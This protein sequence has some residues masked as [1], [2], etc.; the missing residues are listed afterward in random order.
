MFAY[1]PAGNNLDDAAPASRIL[2]LVRQLLILL[3]YALAFTGLRYVASQWAMGQ[4]FSLW[5]PAAGLRFAFLWRFG[6]RLAPAA[7][8]AEFA[9]QMITGAN[10]LEPSPVLAILGIVGPCLAYGAVI[11]LVRKHISGR[12]PIIGSEPLPFA[13]AAVI[14]PLAACV[15]ALPWALPRAMDA[16]V[17]DLPALLTSLL[18]FALGDILGILLI[19][20]PLLWLVQKRRP[21]AEPGQRP[22]GRWIVFE[23]LAVNAA[24]WGLVIAIREGGLG[25]MLAP[26]L[27]ATCWTGLRTGR[28]GAWMVILLAAILVLP[29]TGQELAEA[30]R[31]R[32]HMLLACIAAIGYLAGSFAEAEATSREEIARR[33]RI[34]YQAERLKTLRGMSVALIHEISQP[35]STIALEANNLAALV[36]DPRKNRAEIAE[37]ASLIG[38]KSNDLANLIRRLRRFGD[39]AADGPSPIPVSLILADIMEIGRVE[40]KARNVILDIADESGSAVVLGH[41]IELRQ[42]LLNLVRNAIVASPSHSTVSVE[43]RQAEGRVILAVANETDAATSYRAGMGIGLVIARSIAE[44]H[45]GALREE[46]PAPRQVCFLV[47]LPLLE[48]MND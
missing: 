37:V 11:Y 44:A 41:E 7:A 45:G 36:D 5:F 40:A 46:R 29:A 34:L 48:N 1:E 31:L 33:D 35:L 32:L 30:D 43:A 13:L 22:A 20:P 28:V 25:L 18:V 39:R 19:A 8:L 16:G 15:A 14:G 24:A 47:D 38:R 3:A 17:L 27:L 6:A 12:A 4:M 26:V 2:I 21:R 9:V 23:V 10:S 42:A